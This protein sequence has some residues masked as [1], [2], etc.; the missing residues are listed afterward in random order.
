MPSASP[1]PALGDVEAEPAGV[2]GRQRRQLLLQAET[3]LLVLAAGTLVRDV[4]HLPALDQVHRRVSGG[5]SQRR[6]VA[7]C[8]GTQCSSG[9]LE[10]DVTTS[11]QSLVPGL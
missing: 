11:D 7:G 2:V 4:T 1:E 9:K 6:Q 5:T 10:T 3:V 8:N